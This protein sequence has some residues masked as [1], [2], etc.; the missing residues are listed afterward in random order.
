MACEWDDN[1]VSIPPTLLNSTVKSVRQWDFS[2]ESYSEIC[3]P[4]EVQPDATV[5]GQEKCQQRR[6]L[7]GMADLNLGI[8]QLV[9]ALVL[10]H[11]LKRTSAS[12]AQG[13]IGG[14]RRIQGLRSGL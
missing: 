4:A 10:F 6:L 8:T 13:R 12:I 7:L 2:S 3:S 14:T 5:H 9:T 11:V 1:R